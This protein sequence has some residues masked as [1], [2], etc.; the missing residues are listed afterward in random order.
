MLFLAVFGA[1][2]AAMAVVSQGN[3]RAADSALRVM[4]AQGAAESGLVFAANRLER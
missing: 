2:A 1:L 4:R 3:V